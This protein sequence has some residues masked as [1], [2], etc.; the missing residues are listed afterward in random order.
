MVAD[1]YTA[2]LL[3]LSFMVLNQRYLK[4]HLNTDYNVYTEKKNIIGFVIA[5]LINGIVFQLIIGLKCQSKMLN[6]AAQFFV[7]QI[8]FIIF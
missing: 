4:S 3:G 6:N 1:F 7:M 2:M 8:F 5:Q